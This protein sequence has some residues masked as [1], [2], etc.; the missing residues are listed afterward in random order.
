MQKPSKMIICQYEKRGADN[1]VE[2]TVHVNILLHF[3]LTNL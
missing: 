2:T 3:S 1:F